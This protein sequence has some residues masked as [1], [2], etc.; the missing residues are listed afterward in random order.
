MTTYL[1]M[2]LPKGGKI[3]YTW[4]KVIGAKVTTERDA[5]CQKLQNKEFQGEDTKMSSIQTYWHAK[6]E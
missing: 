1:M 4:H 2:Y 5:K 6:K 3:V